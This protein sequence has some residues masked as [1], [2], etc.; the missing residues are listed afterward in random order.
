MIP[1]YRSDGVVAAL[2]DGGH[3]YNADGDWIGFLRGAEVYDV[4]GGYL[5]YLSSDQRLL[6]RR[7]GPDRERIR[8]PQAWM[9]RLQGLPSHFPLAPLFRQLDYGTVDVFEEDPDRFNFVSDLKPDMD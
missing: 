5:G 7:T 6:R 9:P 4:T 8:P 2:V 3:F 1:V